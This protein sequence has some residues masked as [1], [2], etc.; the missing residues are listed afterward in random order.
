MVG[1][2]MIV[3]FVSF[4]FGI[5]VILEKL[6]HNTAVGWASLIVSIWFMGG[7]IVF[8]LGVIGIY[9]SRIFVETKNRPYVI[10]RRIHQRAAP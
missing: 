8:C 2:G 10:V 9:I 7:M 5:F 3:S 4:A 1:F 6:I